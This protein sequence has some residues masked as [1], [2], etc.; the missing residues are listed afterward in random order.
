MQITLH[1]C[2]ECGKSPSLSDTT[3]ETGSQQVSAVR[4]QACFYRHALGLPYTFPEPSA[5]CS[6]ILHRC[7]L[8]KCQVQAAWRSEGTSGSRMVSAVGVKLGMKMLLQNLSFL[9][10]VFTGSRFSESGS[11]VIR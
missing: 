9:Q 10:K 3:N 11:Q 5:R 4:L 2:G 1:E 7:L 6:F 8:R